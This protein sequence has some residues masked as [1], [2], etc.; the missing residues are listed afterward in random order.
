MSFEFKASYIDLYDGHV[1]NCRHFDNGACNCQWEDLI[2][3]LIFLRKLMSEQEKQIEE[4]MISRYQARN[5]IARL[6][7][8]T[9]WQ[10]KHIE[11]IVVKSVLED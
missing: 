6:R 11:D 9:L 5:E 4:Q 8:T 1:D 2:K 10:R 7:A 3:E